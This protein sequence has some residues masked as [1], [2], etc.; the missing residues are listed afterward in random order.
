LTET[1]SR[2]LAWIT[3]AAGL[4]GSYLVRTAPQFA[5]SWRV[6]GLTREQLDLLDFDAVRR[7]FREQRPQ[8]VIHCAAMSRSPECQAQPKQAHI[9]NVEVTDVLAELATEVPLVFFSTDL[10]F[11]G[12]KGDYREDAPANP[13]NVYAETKVAAEKIVLSN[14]RHLVV[15]TSLNA[16]A[17]P[18][19][20]RT[21]NELTRLLWQR[22]DKVRLFADEFRSPIHA[23][24]TARAV[25]ELV[26]RRV[27]GIIHVAGSE[28]LSRLEIG[29]LQAAR[30]SK[31][32]PQIE[33]ASIRDHPAP[34]R[35]PDTSLNCGKAR[36]LLSFRLPAFGE[37]LRDHPEELV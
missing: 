26:A 19:G 27:T 16:G 6:F 2:P 32:N 23:S 20:D 9:A 30:W 13:L 10:V 25:W 3:G 17:S 7:K 1:N 35:A 34:P 33:V 18:A 31:L 4:I 29:R 28:R 8:L 11:D 24:V 36:K 37:W 21:F 14:P 5:P 12:R 22:G 15:R